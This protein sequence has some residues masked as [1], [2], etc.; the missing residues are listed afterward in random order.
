MLGT[1]VNAIANIVLSILAISIILSNQIIR[2]VPTFFRHHN[3]ARV[4]VSSSPS[5]SAA[6]SVALM[7][8]FA[9]PSISSGQSK[10]PRA[11]RLAQ[12]Q[13]RSRRNR[14]P[15][16]ACVPRCRTRKVARSGDPPPAGCEPIRRARQIPCADRSP[17]L[18]DTP[19]GLLRPGSASSRFPHNARPARELPAH[20]ILLRLPATLPLQIPTDNDPAPQWP[21]PQPPQSA[22][23]RHGLRF[24]SHR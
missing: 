9:T 3:F 18:P 21:E 19:S 7:A 24:P 4:R 8:T 15:S 16:P 13:D 14:A 12:S 5:I 1:G 10:R 22:L 23:L 6:N 11:S 2:L 17:Q 20:Q